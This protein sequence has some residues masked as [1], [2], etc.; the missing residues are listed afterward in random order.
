M[1]PYTQP[2][3]VYWVLTP[4]RTGDNEKEVWIRTLNILIGNQDGTHRQGLVIMGFAGVRLSMWCTI[5]CYVFIFAVKFILMFV[6]LQLL[7]MAGLMSVRL[8]MQ[9]VLRY[10][11][12]VIPTAQRSIICQITHDSW[13]Y[14]EEVLTDPPGSCSNCPM[15]SSQDLIGNALIELILTNGKTL[16]TVI[17]N[18]HRLKYIVGCGVHMTSIQQSSYQVRKGQE[19][20]YI[21]VHGWV[22]TSNTYIKTHRFIIYLS[23]LVYIIAIVYWKHNYHP[24]I[25]LD[26]HNAGKKLI[27]LSCQ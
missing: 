3:L 14:M 7:Y 26:I 10:H 21:V 25:G 6:W 2:R 20:V 18:G 23:I 8:Y 27:Y 13:L 17:K 5:V 15:D 4:H 12:S 19:P 9:M 24:T 1:T 11:T 16:H 22:S